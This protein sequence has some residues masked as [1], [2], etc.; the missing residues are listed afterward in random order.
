MSARAVALGAQILDIL[1][2]PV[3]HIP[4]GQ[5]AA[6]IEQVRFAPAG[7]AAGTAVGMAKLGLEVASVGA[8]GDELLVRMLESYLVDTRY[9]VRKQGTAT[10]V[11][12]LPIRPNGERPALHLPGANLAFSIGDVPWTLLETASYLHI[13]GNDVM[14]GLGRDGAVTI[15]RRAHE[16]GATTTMDMLGEGSPR[17]LPL[18]AQALPF[19]DWFMPNA[20]QACRLTGA[21]T[22]QDAAARLLDG[23]ARGVV[24]TMGEQGSLLMT[25]HERVRL[26]AH[27][28][29]VVDTSGC[30][31]AYCAGF[32]RGLSLGWNA[33]ECMRLGNA[34]A[35]LVAQGLGSDAGIVDLEETLR[36]MN[37]AP[38]VEG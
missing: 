33:R 17:L 23:G 2:R 30:G 36:F 16:W 29:T 18:I 6:L 22:P 26:P 19:V 9:L 38:L 15:V 27:R 8:I 14:R 24:L 3:T 34:A 28:I 13:G 11:S 10:S 4:A 1:A 32:I 31:D 5:G 12:I 21:Q 25:T 20:E 37:T 35:A 7:W